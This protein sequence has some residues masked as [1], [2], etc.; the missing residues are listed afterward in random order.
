MLLQ[1][2]ICFFF[3]FQVVNVK[4][5]QVYSF[6]QYSLSYIF[7]FFKL[8]IEMIRKREYLVHM[9]F[10]ENQKTFYFSLP[11]QRGQII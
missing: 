3:F 6:W 7:F 1:M 10:K 5:L 8:Y 11:L 4:F 2:P 9:N